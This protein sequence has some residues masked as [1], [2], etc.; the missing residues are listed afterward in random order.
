MSESTMTGLTFLLAL[1]LL[2]IWVI[3][4]ATGV[5]ASWLA[6][7]VFVAGVLALFIA[8]GGGRGATRGRAGHTP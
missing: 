7:L 4:L 3:A 6:W 2:A 5:A 8:I 1:G